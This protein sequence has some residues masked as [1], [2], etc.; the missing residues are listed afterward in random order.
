MLS[1]YHL[2]K[3]DANVVL[4][5]RSLLQAEKCRHRHSAQT[6]QQTNKMN[7]LKCFSENALCGVVKLIYSYLLFDEPLDKSAVIE[8]ILSIWVI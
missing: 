1:W 8:L 4:E 5:V 7:L 3:A 2:G 6:L